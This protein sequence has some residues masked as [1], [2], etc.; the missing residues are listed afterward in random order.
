MS[1][2]SRNDELCVIR[3]R[4]FDGTHGD[5][6]LHQVRRACTNSLSSM[7]THTKQ[8]VLDTMRKVDLHDAVR[9]KHSDRELVESMDDR[10]QPIVNLTHAHHSLHVLTLGY[11]KTCANECGTVTERT[12]FV[13]LSVITRETIRLVVTRIPSAPEFLF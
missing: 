2:K 1:M 8:S 13:G 11:A 4:L 9:R 5:E 6:A 7:M 10:I 12:L 3:V